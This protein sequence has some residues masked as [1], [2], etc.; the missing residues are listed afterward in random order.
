MVAA[1]FSEDLIEFFYR[2]RRP[3]RVVLE[4]ACERFVVGGNGLGDTGAV[5]SFLKSLSALCKKLAEFGFDRI[6][7]IVNRGGRSELGANPFQFGCSLD[8]VLF[9]RSFRLACEL[10]RY[11]HRFSRIFDRTL[12]MLCAL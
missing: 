2:S 3:V 5:R 1:L 11:D 8:S 4:H 7:L 9:T 6:A 10:V 12:K